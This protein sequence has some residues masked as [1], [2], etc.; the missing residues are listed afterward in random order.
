MDWLLYDR[1]L[2]HERVKLT[3]RTSVTYSNYITRATR[4]IIN[5]VCLIINPF[6]ANVTILHP[7]EKKNRKPETCYLFKKK[8]Q[9]RCF[10]VNFAKYLRSPFL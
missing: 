10:P 3:I 8:F 7:L 6:L 5:S 9:H 1:D 4:E 2:R